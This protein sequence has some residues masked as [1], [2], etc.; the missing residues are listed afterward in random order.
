MHYLSQIHQFLT[1]S[2]NDDE[3]RTLCFRINVDYDNLSGNT[4]EGKARELI[5][6]LDRRGELNQLLVQLQKDRPKRYQESGLRNSVGA[7]LFST[8]SSISNELQQHIYVQAFQSLVED[9]TKEF[10]GR[11]FVFSAIDNLLTDPTFPSGY[12]IMNGE[13]G[14]GKTSIIAELVKRRG[15][16]HHFNSITRNIRSTGD[17]LA[18]IC[19]QLI[20]RFELNYP[21]LPPATRD[22]SRTLEE[23]LSKAAATV[24]NQ[25]L[26][27]LVDALD[28]S[29]DLDL[30]DGTNCL[31]LPPDLPKNVYFIITTRELVDYRLVVANRRDIN[32]QDDSPENLKDIRQYIRHYLQT[33]STSLVSRLKEWETNEDEFLDVITQKSQ[34]NFMY[35]VY[36][37]SDINTGKL[38]VAEVDNIRK[39]PQ[40]LQAYYLLHWRR[41]G[42]AAPP[43]PHT[44]LKIIYL[45]SVIKSPASRISLAEWSGEKEPVV[46]QILD[47]WRQF[48]HEQNI[49]N[50]KH[51][52]LYH[53][54]FRDFLHDKDIVEAARA[55]IPGLHRLIAHNLYIK[56]Y[57]YEE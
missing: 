31:F 12:I 11:E 46:Q 7:N 52:S 51:Y 42:M 5:L 43:L 49:D 23:L 1:S 17:F 28:E 22:N 29:Q 26:V 40:G 6:Y 8:Y 13:P 38:S 39:L 32:L 50:R 34:G 30:P 37:L 3:V 24:E 36:V 57:G 18:N 35:L 15:Y 48:L 47:E 16:V 25:P 56:A 27:I 9:R 55:D 4:L 19:A 20:V 33:H 53:A 14:I 54:S 2:H 10:I 45:L 44:K 41:M 21:L